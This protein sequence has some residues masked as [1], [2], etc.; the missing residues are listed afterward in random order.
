MQIL[1]SHL[2]KYSSPAQRKVLVLAYYRSGSTLTGQMFNYN[3]SAFYWFEPLAAVSRP[4]GWVWDI[5][6]PRNWYHYDNGTEKYVTSVSVIRTRRVY[7][8]KII[9]LVA[10]WDAKYDNRLI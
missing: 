6:P 7:F 8:V 4:W 5:I 3:P 1:Q 2:L 9:K 10:H